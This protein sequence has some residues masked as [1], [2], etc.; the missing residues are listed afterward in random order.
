MRLPFGK[1]LLI[2]LTICFLCV[3]SNCNLSNSLFGFEGR[4]SGL[5]PGRL[6]ITNVP[7]A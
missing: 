4:M 1:D 7:I 5:I 3:V 2:R 6:L